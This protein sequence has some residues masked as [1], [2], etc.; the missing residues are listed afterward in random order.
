MRLQSKSPLEVDH[1]EALATQDLKATFKGEGAVI[2]EVDEESQMDDGSAADPQR[3]SILKGE[4]K[5]NQESQP[6]G[7]NIKREPMPTTVEFAKDNKI[8]VNGA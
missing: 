2:H 1:A 5:A 3:H 4:K 7:D 6:S 8:N